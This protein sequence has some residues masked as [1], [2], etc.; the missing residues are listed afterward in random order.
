MSETDERA[1][2]AEAAAR[3][4]ARVAN[5]SFRTDIPVEEKGEDDV[6]TEADRAAR[7]LLERLGECRS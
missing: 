5:D 2:V 6:V 1:A 3:A 7:W 4:G